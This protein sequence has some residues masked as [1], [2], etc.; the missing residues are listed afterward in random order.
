[1]LVRLKASFSIFDPFECRGAF[2]N[3]AA[4]LKSPPELADIWLKA[5]IRNKT[6]LMWHDV[7]T[8]YWQALLRITTEAEVLLV[9]DEHLL[10]WPSILFG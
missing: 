3:F 4:C 9:K 10:D 7:Q 8:N 5:V 1:M 6:P 2:N